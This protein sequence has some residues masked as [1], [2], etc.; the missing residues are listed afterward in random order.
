MP[1]L[2]PPAAVRPAQEHHRVPQQPPLGECQQQLGR[3]CLVSNGQLRQVLL[4]GPSTLLL[5]TSHSC[6]AQPLQHLANTLAEPAFSR[7]RLIGRNL[8]QSGPTPYE[9][10]WENCSSFNT[11]CYCPGLR[12]A[13]PPLPLAQTAR[14][15]ANG[16]WYPLGAIFNSNLLGRDSRDCRR[17]GGGR[18]GFNGGPY[19][20]RGPFN[21]GPGF[22]H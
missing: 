12:P 18:R 14:R 20:G 7:S 4:R 5:R 21:G 3:G 17:I 1:C 11:Q 10:A 22:G 19:N 2:G 9:D 15:R 6:S 16:G 13:L 8:P